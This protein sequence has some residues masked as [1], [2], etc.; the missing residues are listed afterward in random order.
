MKTLATVISATTLAALVS[1]AFAGGQ[2]GPLVSAE[3]I[4]DETYGVNALFLEDNARTQGDD[5][6]H[7]AISVL[8]N[9]HWIGEA[10]STVGLD[11]DLNVN[12]LAEGGTVIEFDKTVYNDTNNFWS[13]FKIELHPEGATSLIVDALANSAFEDVSVTDDGSGNWTIMWGMGAGG[14]GVAGGE[15]T[16]LEFSLVVFGDIHFS[17]WQ[18]AIPAPGALALLAVAGF[19][20]R[21][22]RNA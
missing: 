13:G 9:E 19:G 22:R 14:T 18:T 6:D 16:T 5:W 20:S 15:S 3:I 17:M 1:P 4:A 11:I 10:G 12:E 2:N 8:L 21:R 7:D